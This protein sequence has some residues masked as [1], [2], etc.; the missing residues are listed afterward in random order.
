VLYADGRRP[1]FGRGGERCG[2]TDENDP[3]SAHVV[4][5]CRGASVGCV[6]LT[7]I[8]GPLPS[9]TEQMIGAA[10]LRALLTDIG[11]EA[12]RV[13]E[14]GRWIV[15]PAYKHLGIGVYLMSASFALA[16]KLGFPSSVATVSRDVIPILERAG[17]RRAPGIP[18]LRSEAFNDEVE[19]LYGHQ[20]EFHPAVLGQFQ[21]MA[22]WMGL[23][24]VY[25]H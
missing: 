14:H 11:A 19:V 16:Y 9:V 18:L 17:A 3:Y 5:R 25:D 10:R 24:V 12:A 21:R 8:L 20:R 6:R 7:P 2:D 23:G 15:D 4:A 13:V 22:E 1:E